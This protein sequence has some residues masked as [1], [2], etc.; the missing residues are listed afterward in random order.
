MENKPDENPVLKA[1]LDKAIETLT[2][3]NKDGYYIYLIC[4]NKDKKD[5]MSWQSFLSKKEI[6]NKLE[7]LL[8]ELLPDGKVSKRMLLI[9][10]KIKNKANE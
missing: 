9:M 7:Q 3:L 5:L 6:T 10:K 2:K 1:N 8:S 4:A